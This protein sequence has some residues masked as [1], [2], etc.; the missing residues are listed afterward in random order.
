METEA[1]LP[2][3]G[4][5]AVLVVDDEAEVREFIQTVLLSSGLEVVMAKDGVECMETFEARRQDIG[6][7]LL[8]LTMPRM[9][10]DEALRRLRELEAELPVILSSG[11]DEQEAFSRIRDSGPVVYLQKPYRAARLIRL[12]R[13]QL[14]GEET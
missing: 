6:L 13:E 7:V 5:G 14:G 9:N 2:W 8:D 11:Y 3:A 4:R 1:A 12:V 10:G